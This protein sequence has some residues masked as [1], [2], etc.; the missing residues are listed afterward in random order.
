MLYRLIKDEAKRQE[1]TINLIASENIVSEEVMEI[2]GSILT[3]KYAEGY[4]S[5]RYYSGCE[6]IDL[7]EKLAQERLK[8]IF[9]AL[10]YHANVQPH[11]GSQANMAVYMSILE[12]GDTILSMNLNDGG[13]LSHGSPVSFSGKDYK[14]ISYG[15]NE[16]GYIDY[17]NVEKLAMEYTPKLIVCGAS[18]YPRTID[19]KRF[20]QI[21]DRVGAYLLADIAHTA[22]LV[23]AGLHPTPVG[24][25]DFITMT[26]QKT[27]RGP[28][29]GAILCKEKFAKA[30][31]SSV[32]PGIQGGPI[33]NIIAAKCQCFYEAGSEDFVK[34]QKRVIKNVK[35][36][37]EVYNAYGVKLVSGASD[38]HLLLID[39]KTSFG[40]TGKD[41][42]TIL[43]KLGVYVN[44]NVLPFDKEKPSVTSGIR[45]GSAYMTTRGLKEYDFKLIADIIV[46]ALKG[47]ERDVTIKERVKDIVKKCK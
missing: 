43:S 22:G 30:I 13:H 27:L 46:C 10:K 15:V 17:D 47:L 26:T 14:I 3:N 4:P 2:T 34:Y 6:N 12:K 40:I 38:H 41:S 8:E 44:K 29:G 25:A 16:D 23:V 32:F 1:S 45:V 35:A 37:E 33:E 28:R 36:M 7:I 42:E 24:Y 19:F 31:D 11:S 9:K 21:A 5:K 18:S 20:R 39:T